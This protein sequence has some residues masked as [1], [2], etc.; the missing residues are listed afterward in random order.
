MSVLLTVEFPLLEHIAEK[1]H[2]DMHQNDKNV[3]NRKNMLKYNKY[4]L[5]K[6][7]PKQTIIST[8]KDK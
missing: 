4:V 3:T 1:M 7:I 6:T 8:N 2:F 5:Q